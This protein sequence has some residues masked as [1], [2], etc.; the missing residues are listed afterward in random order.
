LYLDRNCRHTGSQF[1]MR[2]PRILLTTSRNPTD[3]LRT[4][5]NDLARILP[6]ALRV[7][8]GK[9]S[10][11]Q[12]AEK[13]LQEGSEHILLI[14]R[15]QSGSGCIRFWKTQQTGL[16]CVPPVIQVVDMK[17]R[18]DFKIPSKV[19][20]ARGIAILPSVPSDEARRFAEMLAG[21]LGVPLLSVDEVAHDENLIALDQDGIGRLIVT[22][23]TGLNHVEVGP[24]V[25]VVKMEWALGT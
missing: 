21:F 17:L 19:K 9:M 18:R 4:L 5:C 22:F 15:G 24:R 20:P 6:N 14:E 7:N 10:N 23:I 25:T 8:R 12:L 11:E 3:R 1:G 16:V 13:A 2:A